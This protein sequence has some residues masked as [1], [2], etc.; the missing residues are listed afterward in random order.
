LVVGSGFRGNSEGSSGAYNNSATN[1]GFLQLQRVENEQ[2]L[3]VPAGVPSTDTTFTT[4]TLSGLPFGHYR[5]TIIAER[6]LESAALYRTR[7]L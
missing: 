1:I 6:H 4:G 5:M 2:T 7:M 3:F